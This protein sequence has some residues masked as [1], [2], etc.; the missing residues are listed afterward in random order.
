MEVAACTQAPYMDRDE[1]A[2]V[3]GVEPSTGAHPADRLRRRLRRQARRFGAAAARGRG[4]RDR[5]AGA[6]RLQPHRVHGLDHQAAPGAHLGEGLRRRGR[7]AHRL[8]VGGG[9]QHRRLCLLGA[10]GREPRAGPRERA[11]QG[12]ECLEP[13]PRDLHQRHAGRR[14]SR[15]RRAAGGDRARDADGRSRRGARARPLAD[16]P[17]QRAR[18]RRHDAVGPGAR[19]IPPGC[20][21]ASTR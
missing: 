19:S 8:R 12:A 15:L 3:L 4:A 20:R 11:L 14:L 21:N 2:R 13:Q 5:Q 17:H 6:H 1:T 16:P 9:F 18:P 7:P 10:D